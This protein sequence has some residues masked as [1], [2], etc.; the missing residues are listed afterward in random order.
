MVETPSAAHV[1]GVC[2]LEIV[3]VCVCVC[4]CVKQ[5][6]METLYTEAC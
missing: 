4:V 5:R 6:G 2:K 1:F 3:C